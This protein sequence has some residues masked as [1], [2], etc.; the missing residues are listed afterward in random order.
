MIDGVDDRPRERRIIL[1]E[2]WGVVR[3]VP[4][5]DEHDRIVQQAVS[6]PADDSRPRAES[7]ARPPSASK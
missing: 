6:S 4:A 5:L 1:G 3:P 7:S 2:E